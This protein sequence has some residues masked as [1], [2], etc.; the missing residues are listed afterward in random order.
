MCRGQGLVFL[1]PKGQEIRNRAPNK[2]GH[3]FGL[4]EGHRQ[5]PGHNPQ[6]SPGGNAEDAGVLSGPGPQRP[7]DGLGH[8]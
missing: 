3:G 4:L 6:G 2:S 5:R 8:A 1:Q 7:K